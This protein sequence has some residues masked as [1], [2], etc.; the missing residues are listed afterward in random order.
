MRNLSWNE[1]SGLS[2]PAGVRWKPCGADRGAYAWVKQ[3]INVGAGLN[4]A[5][6][7]DVYE[8]PLWPVWEIIANAVLHRTYLGSGNVQI[9]LCD[10]RLEISSP[11]GIPRGLTMRQAL[12]GRPEFRD[13]GLAQGFH[14]MKL[15]EGWGSGIPRAISETI[16]FGLKPPE[17]IDMGGTIRVNFSHP[18][19]EEFESILRDDIPASNSWDFQMLT[20]MEND[21]FNNAASKNTQTADISA[22]TAELQTATADILQCFESV[23]IHLSERQR[24][25]AVYMAQHSPAKTKQAALAIGLSERRT[26]VILHE[27]VEA[28]V[29][30]KEGATKASQYVLNPAFRIGGDGL[31]PQEKDR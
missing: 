9:A 8:L 23:G 27:M 24:D 16:A 18:T 2:R 22:D 21:A 28:G 3:K 31:M 7:R 10:D 26:R 12:D 25:A 20:P 6:R 30:S 17:F 11:G 5:V 29:V 15:V 4:G 14:Y 19:V 13:K 1:Q